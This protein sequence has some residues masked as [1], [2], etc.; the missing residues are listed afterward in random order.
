MIFLFIGE[1]QYNLDDKGRLFIPTDFRNVLRDK[2]IV[3]RG[4]EACLFIYA[5][6]DWSH[7]VDKISNLSFTKKSHREFSRM[8]LSGAF[9]KDI[10]SK[11]RINIDSNLLTYAGLTKECIIIGV[12]NRIEIWDKEKW[13]SYYED[14]QPVLDQISEEIDLD[15]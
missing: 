10:D 9:L 12:G 5:Q 15:V 3:S 11:G 8:F 14:H 4:I 6:E 1:Y 2:L 13:N 7:L